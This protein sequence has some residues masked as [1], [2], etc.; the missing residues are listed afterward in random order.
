MSPEDVPLLPDC[1]KRKL[2]H[3]GL[4]GEIDTLSLTSIRSSNRFNKTDQ[5]RAS[6]PRE[7][8]VIDEQQGDKILRSTIG[9]CCSKKDKTLIVE[10]ATHH[11]HRDSISPIDK[12]DGSAMEIK[13]YSEGCSQKSKL[14]CLSEMSEKSDN[15]SFASSS[16]CE[17]QSPEKSTSF[18][19]SS[20]KSNS[21]PSSNLQ[22]SSEAVTATKS[23]C[24]RRILSVSPNYHSPTSTSHHGTFQYTS[25]YATGSESFDRSGGKDENSEK[26]N[27]SLISLTNVMDDRETSFNSSF[28]SPFEETN[29]S[30]RHS[31]S[32]GR[33]GR[34]RC[35]TVSS[36]LFHETSSLSTPHRSSVSSS[37]HYP[38]HVETPISGST[39][40]GIVTKNIKF[41]ERVCEY[42][43]NVMDLSESD[44]SA[45]NQGGDLPGHVINES[46]AVF[47]SETPMNVSCRSVFSNKTTPG[48]ME[49]GPYHD[50][51]R[52]GLG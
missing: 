24:S 44:E 9:N 25:G 17:Y 1:K 35:G 50:L 32:S 2:C 47:A 36:Y 38:P 26:N 40:S 23:D 41:D 34:S 14:I 10:T 37:D 29:E 15:N 42:E 7:H 18:L 31:E 22:H 27:E 52:G 13:H 16:S 45:T 33:L 3:T 12:G 21:V 5:V 4:T 8:C 30:E 46:G 11:F 51:L 19:G 28:S 6:T 43:A 49:V 20:S 39:S 48:V